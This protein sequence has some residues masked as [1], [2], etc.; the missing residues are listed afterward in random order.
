MKKALPCPT[1]VVAFFWARVSATN[2]VKYVI[3]FIG[4]VSGFGNTYPGGRRCGA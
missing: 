1:I 4:T 3:P 2:L